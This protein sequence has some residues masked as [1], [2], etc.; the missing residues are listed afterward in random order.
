MAEC[1][2][3]LSDMKREFESRP[4]SEELNELLNTKANKPTVAQALHR[5]ANKGEVD[6]ILAHKVD[7]DEFQKL[8]NKLNEK[9]NYIDL[10]QIHD[11][12]DVKVDRS[13]LQEYTLTRGGQSSDNIDKTLFN[14]LA[15][16]RE[17]YNSRI[18]NF[19]NEVRSALSHV[20]NEI[21]EVIDNFNMGLSKKADYRDLDSMNAAIVNK[22]DIDSMSSLVNET[23]S[24]LLEKL[25]KTKDEITLQKKELAEDLIERHNKVTQKVDKCAKDFKL[26]KD[27]N[28]DFNNETSKMRNDVKEI[29]FKEAE[30]VNSQVRDE[31]NKA[32]DELHTTRIKLENEI[33]QKVKKSDL[34]EIKNDLINR[35]ESKVDLS[36]VQNAL[37][38]LQ[39]EVANRLINTKLE[40]QNTISSAQEYMNHQ[41]AKK[42]N[43]EDMNELLNSKV[44]YNQMRQ[45]IENKANRSDFEAMRDALDRLIRDIDNKASNKELQNHIEFTRSSIEDITKE[46]IQK[47][48]SRDLI[49]VA[50]EKANREEVEKIF[51][52][53]QS[54]LIE[55]ASLKELKT[56]LDEQ[57]LINEAL[58]SE[59]CIGRWVWKSGELKA[60][61]LIPWEIQWVNTWPDNFV[62]E[63]NKTSI[64]CVSP[65]LYEIG[66]GFYSKKN[67]NVEVQINGEGILT[68]F[69]DSDIAEKT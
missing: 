41:L 48:K 15:K 68:L 67:P 13:E 36:E 14:A 2:N 56:S 7:I 3:Y 43:T 66:A 62:W 27:S 58:C 32:I 64:I 10:K 51:Q 28:K 69:K 60:S 46:I 31:I 45:V 55:K 24:L 33:S 20:E 37:N 21:K 34:I 40:L 49:S 63:K 29:I 11:I 35:W 42:I 38:S 4:T 8:A 47:A 30:L 19:E 52:T 17:I 50:E 39:T 54:E 65:G 22:A 18:E 57:S 12:L 61:C 25:R 26:L 59:N 44:D 5:K 1:E 6:E 53:L 23:K 16:D 9:A